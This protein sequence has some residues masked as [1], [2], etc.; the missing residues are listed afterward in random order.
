[1]EL[2]DGN[3]KII[4]QERERSMLQEQREEKR[5]FEQKEKLEKVSITATV[6]VGEDDRIFGTVTTQNVSDLL[7]EKGYE[8]D[9][10]QISLEEQV[11][12]LGIYPVKIK[13]HQN[14]EADIKL[15]VV[16]DKPASE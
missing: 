2:T 1:M 7:K 5:A 10:K 16:K 8:I 11:K 15:W 9:K 14:V 4:E 6:T 3:M 12:A 13:L